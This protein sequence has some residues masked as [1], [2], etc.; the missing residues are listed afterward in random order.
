MDN[1][2]FVYNKI[3]DNL[4]IYKFINIY[5]NQYMGNKIVPSLTV[6][7][8]VFSIDIHLIIKIINY[9][10]INVWKSLDT[11]HVIRKKVCDIIVS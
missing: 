10:T 8:I 1:M 11:K 7:E 6:R 4:L 2:S 5:V 3:Y 9:Y